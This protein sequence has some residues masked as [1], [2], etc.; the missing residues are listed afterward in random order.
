M[1]VAA[2]EKG[3]LGHTGRGSSRAF[4][5]SAIRLSLAFLVMIVSNFRSPYNIC[6]KRCLRKTLRSYP[7]FH[8][9]AVF[10]SVT[11]MSPTS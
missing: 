2:T 8:I 4:G 10:T 5:G 11:H 6:M 7:V 9:L 3:S 1:Q